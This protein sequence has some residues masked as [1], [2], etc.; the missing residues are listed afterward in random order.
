MHTDNK[1]TISSLEDLEKVI[2]VEL[3]NALHSVI[4]LTNDLGQTIMTHQSC[5]N[6]IYMCECVRRLTHICLARSLVSLKQSFSL[7]SL[8]RRPWVKELRDWK[9]YHNVKEGH[10]S[11]YRWM[12]ELCVCVRAIFLSLDHQLHSWPPLIAQKV[13]SPSPDKELFPGI[14]AES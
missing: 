7:D 1:Q 3:W 6:S 14:N 13:D 12:M 9:C 2:L 8:S 4:W 11:P 5:S 10:N